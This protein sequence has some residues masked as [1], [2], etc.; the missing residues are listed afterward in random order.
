MADNEAMLARTLSGCGS[1]YGNVY[2]TPAYLLTLLKIHENA[3]ISA[4][5]PDNQN[6]A[7]YATEFEKG[8]S[9]LAASKSARKGRAA[10]VVETRPNAA[11]QRVPALGESCM[12]HVYPV[13]GHIGVFGGD[14]ICVKDG[15]DT[16]NFL[17][18]FTGD[19]SVVLRTNPP[20]GYHTYS[21]SEQH[22][23]LVTDID[24]RVLLWMDGYA[25]AGAIGSSAF[26]TAA[27]AGVRKQLGV[28]TLDLLTIILRGLPYL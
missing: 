7:S 12:A 4:F 16:T 10:P 20:R 28:T 27:V 6:F 15:R 1:P 9:I 26:A 19:D 25:S 18:S 17:T 11:A 8:Y 14:R 24:G 3:E 5:V 21:S 22:Y 13:V 23:Q 2:T